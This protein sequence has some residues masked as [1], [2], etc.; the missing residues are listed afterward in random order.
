MDWN[1]GNMGSLNVNDR[2]LNNGELNNPKLENL[3]NLALDSSLE[4]GEKSGVLD[5]GFDFV[6]DSW[7][8]IVK[9]NGNIERLDSEVIRIQTLL[10]GYAIVTIRRDLIE[11]FALLDEVEFVEIPKRL[12]FE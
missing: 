6:T 11:P 2:N 7:E 9:F 4:E 5:L 3:L 10:N 1:Y 8:I 12:Y